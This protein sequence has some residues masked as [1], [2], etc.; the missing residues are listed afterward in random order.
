MSHARIKG[1]LAHTP[2][3]QRAEAYEVHKESKGIFSQFPVHSNILVLHTVSKASFKTLSEIN[4]IMV[5]FLNKNKGVV[6]LEL[7]A[8]KN[9]LV[10]MAGELIVS[11]LA[12]VEMP[13]AK[14]AQDPEASH[15]GVAL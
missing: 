8:L 11:S 12:G 3:S 2:S 4:N 5:F 13:K 14:R 7:D 10:V 9:E 6:V 1:N 15:A